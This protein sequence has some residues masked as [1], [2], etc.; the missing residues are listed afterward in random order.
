MDGV[1]SCCWSVCPPGTRCTASDTLSEGSA[2]NSWGEE[3]PGGRKAPTCKVIGESPASVGHAG[4]IRCAVSSSFPNFQ[5]PCSSRSS[6]SFPIYE[7]MGSATVCWAFTRTVRLPECYEVA[8]SDPSDHPIF[9]RWHSRSSA[10]EGDTRCSDVRR[11]PEGCLGAQPSGN[12]GP[13][14]ALRVFWLAPFEPDPFPSLMQA[15]PG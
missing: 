15:L 14:R 13:A 7:V 3:A 11:A 2:A 5:V 4:L 12:R 1:S 10:Q 9:A 8:E 6:P